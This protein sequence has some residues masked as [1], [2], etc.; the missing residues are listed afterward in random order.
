V[1]GR[2]D[3]EPAD[4]KVPVI[5]SDGQPK[6]EGEGKQ[7]NVLRVSLRHS[8]FGL[9]PV[10]SVY[11]LAKDLDRHRMQRTLHP[12]EL[13]TLADREDGKVLQRLGKGVAG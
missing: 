5:R 2:N 1:R 7:I 3:G 11:L 6:V 12:F 9:L 8:P 13:K 10:R 4:C